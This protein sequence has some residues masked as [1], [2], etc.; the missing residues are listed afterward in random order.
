VQVRAGATLYTRLGD[1]PLVG[2]YAIVLVGALLE[3][4]RARPRPSL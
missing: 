2:A 3:A 1:A 4:V